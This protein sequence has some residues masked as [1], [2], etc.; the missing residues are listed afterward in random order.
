MIISGKQKQILI[1]GFCQAY[2]IDELTV[3][4]R[5]GMEL[6]LQRIQQGENYDLIVANL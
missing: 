4:L 5:E 3:H 1:E 2:H 6:N